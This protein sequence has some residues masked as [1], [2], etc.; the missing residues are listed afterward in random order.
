VI[1]RI[2]PE[3]YSVID[4]EF[5]YLQAM[6]DGSKHPTD[7]A[8]ELAADSLLV[9]HRAGTIADRLEYLAACE[10]TEHLVE[11]DGGRYAL[12]EDGRA[13]WSPRGSSSGFP[14]VETVEVC[15][16][17]R[18]GRTDRPGGRRRRTRRVIPAAE[19][20]RAALTY[21]RDKPQDC[22]VSRCR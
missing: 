6:C 8:A 22:A 13:C 17:P 14:T 15:A 3:R 5:R 18:P 12:T 7:I 9:E 11:C 20:S 16:P 10:G 1:E 2:S 21:R 19:A 4:H